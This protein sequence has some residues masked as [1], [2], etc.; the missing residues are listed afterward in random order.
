MNVHT[1]ERQ[2]NESQADYRKRQAA[3]KTAVQRMTLSTP[4]VR[5]WAVEQKLDLRFRRG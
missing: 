5:K 4:A 2:P 3:S 1:P